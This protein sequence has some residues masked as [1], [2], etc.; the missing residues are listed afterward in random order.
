M[1]HTHRLATISLAIVLSMFALSAGISRADPSPYCRPVASPPYTYSGPVLE[2]P[3]IYGFGV[4]GDVSLHCNGSIHAGSITAILH[5]STDGRAGAQRGS[6]VGCKGS[7]DAAAYYH[8]H[9]LH[10]GEYYY[11]DDYVQIVGWWQR[12]A[13]SD[14]VN[15]SLDGRH[16]KGSS[17]F[18]SVCR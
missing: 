2:R 17:H 1:R 3:G 6:S 18:P 8:R 4:E 10:C 14:K 12:T 11:Y 15:V 13:S 9:G 5:Y 16:T 7:C